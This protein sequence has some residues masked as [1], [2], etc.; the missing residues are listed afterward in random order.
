MKDL[1]SCVY[2]TKIRHG[3][4][5]FMSHNPKLDACI[6]AGELPGGELDIL[7]PYLPVGIAYYLL[8]TM[9]TPAEVWGC[10]TDMV[11]SRAGV[12]RWFRK[13]ISYDGL[14]LNKAHQAAQLLRQMEGL[15]GAGRLMPRDESYPQ[16]AAAAS[17]HLIDDF[18]STVRRQKILRAMQGRILFAEEVNLILCGSSTGTS[19]GGQ[20][21]EAGSGLFDDLQ[22]LALRGAVEIF[23]AMGFT[24]PGEVTCF[25]CGLKASLKS[26]FLRGKPGYGQIYQSH[27][28]L[29]SY[30]SIYCQQCGSMGESRLCRPLFALSGKVALPIENDC[31]PG[32]S[33]VLIKCP[34]GVPP[35]TPAQK[36]AA[37]DLVDFV[38]DRKGG[39]S[40]VWAV[41]GA[42]K[43]EVVLEAAAAVLAGGGRVLY[44]IPRR[45]VVCE[46][47][48][49]LKSSFPGIEV[50]ALYGGSTE[51]FSSSPL[52]IAT[53][54]QVLRYYKCFDLV[55]VDEVDAYPYKENEMLHMAVRRA[56]RPGGH[57]ICLTATPEAKTLTEARKGSIRLITLPARYHGHPVPEPTMLKTAPCKPGPE[58]WEVI[59]VVSEVL[60]RWSIE[61]QAQVFVFV[62]TV[63][64]VKLYGPALEKA[65]ASWDGGIHTGIICCSYAGDPLRDNKRESFKAGVYR[66]FVTTSIMERG[67][68]VKHANVLVLEADNETVFDAGALVQM[69]GRAGRSAQFPTGEVLF[70]GARVSGTMKSALKQIR[71]LNNIA[72]RQGYLNENE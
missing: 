45:D 26:S 31:Y 48:P 72:R 44:A 14:V 60:Y 17:S 13:E 41:T 19:Q 10:D 1:L 21:I 55:I 20:V 4:R 66:I 18:L 52:V 35:L 34:A 61:E 9:F 23:P 16:K 7:T 25:R 39:H 3:Y 57:T 54:H 15:L 70:M 6:L 27:C 64:L 53:T 2:I 68:T 43:T 62:P 56:T 58:G 65:V 11:K 8:R 12:F 40:L 63:S 47:L 24:A 38:K 59:P 50:S 46:L 29:C 5:A 33:R 67:I 28:S 71:L 37:R 36:R 22:V 32:K 30:P 69:A 49:R 42:G 51:K